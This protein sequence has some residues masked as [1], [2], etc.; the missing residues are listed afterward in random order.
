MNTDIDQ[1]MDYAANNA[2]YRASLGIITEG[3]LNKTRITWAAHNPETGDFWFPDI[4][5]TLKRDP[6]T[7]WQPLTQVQL[8]LYLEARRNG[9]TAHRTYQQVESV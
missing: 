2:G 7:T 1:A 9:P 4:E 3:Q 5:L 8:R 6:S